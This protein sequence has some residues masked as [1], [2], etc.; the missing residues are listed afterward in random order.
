MIQRLSS[1]LLMTLLFFTVNAQE[2]YFLLDPTLSPDA[3]T[4]V[5]G[6]DVDLWKVNATVIK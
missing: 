4:I 3:K 1:I 2:N 5:F 6:H